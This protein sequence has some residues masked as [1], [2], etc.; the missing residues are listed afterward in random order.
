MKHNTFFMAATGFLLLAGGIFSG[1][2]GS[3]STGDIPAVGG[4]ELERYLGKW[5]EIARLPH[6]FERGLDFVVAEYALRDDGRVRVVN[7]GVRDGKTKSVEGVARFK[8]SPE[9]GL[10]EVSFFRPFYGDYR[11]ILLEKD[12]SAALVAGEN[13]DYLWILSRSPE[14]DAGKLE[15]YLAFAR[16]KG[17]D[18]DNLEYPKQKK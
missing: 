9:T 3:G 16:E 11:I 14:L 8:G 18:V 17:F 12:Y 7:S 15:E 1:C 5:Y 10:L 2:S 4:F 13:R 6:R